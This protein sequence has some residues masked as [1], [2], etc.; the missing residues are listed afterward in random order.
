MT[1]IAVVIIEGKTYFHVCRE[2]EPVER[3]EVTPYMALQHAARLLEN[4]PYS[5]VQK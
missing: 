1:R 3:I 2:N 4:I 5:K